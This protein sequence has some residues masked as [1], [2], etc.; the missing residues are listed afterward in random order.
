MIFVCSPRSEVYLPRRTTNGVALRVDGVVGRS[1][2][3]RI[4][5]VNQLQLIALSQAAYDV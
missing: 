1:H 3:S 4:V 2:R 5:R